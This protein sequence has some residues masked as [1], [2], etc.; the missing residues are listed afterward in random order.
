[1]T[2]PVQ[3]DK[4]KENRQAVAP[5]NFVP[6]PELIVTQRVEELP[7]QGKYHPDRLTGYLDCELT[8]ES[9]VFV[10]AG[11]TPEQA[12]IMTCL[13]EVQ[14]SCVMSLSFQGVCLGSGDSRF[15]RKSNQCLCSPVQ[16]KLSSK[17]QV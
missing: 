2:L 3:P 12:K 5:Y 15:R 4:I 1:M 9:P 13:F 8:T 14:H 6:L 11:I 10:R 16:T 17:C 7:D